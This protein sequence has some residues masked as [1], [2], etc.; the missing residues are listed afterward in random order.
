[1]LNKTNLGYFRVYTGE[2]WEVGSADDGISGPTRQPSSM[3][4]MSPI[5]GRSCGSGAVQ[6]SPTLTP[7]KNS[8][9]SDDSGSNSSSPG[10]KSS[11]T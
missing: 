7:S 9:H 10:S 4:T 8:S 6:S 11:E 3:N 1:M 2:G 5:M